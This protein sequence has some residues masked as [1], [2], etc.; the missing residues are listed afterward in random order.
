M[1]RIGLL[2]SAI[3]AAV[4]TMISC[5]EEIPSAD[6]TRKEWPQCVKDLVQGHKDGMIYSSGDIAGNT[7]VVTF[8][9]GT[10]ISIDRDEVRV[11]DCRYR[12]IPE[13]STKD[14]VWVVN[15][16]DSG[17][18]VEECTLEESQVV[19]IYFTDSSLWVVFSNGDKLEFKD[20]ESY[21]IS[22]FVFEAANNPQFEND[23]VCEINGAN[24][25]VV[26]PRTPES[27]VLVPTITSM[28]KEIRCGSETQENSV[29]S[30]DF[31]NP[32]KYTLILQDN[33]EFTY[34]VTVKSPIDFPTV[35]LVTENGKPITSKEDY[36]RGTVRF[37]DPGKVYSEVT[38]LELPT[39]LRGRGNTTW[40]LSDKKPYRIKLDEK[41]PVFGQAPN[42]D[43]TL[44]ANYSDKSLLRNIACMQ[45][46][47][48]AGFPWIPVTYSVDVYLNGEYRGV[49]TFS[50]QVEVGKSRIDIEVVEEGDV[51]GD[52]VT[53]GYLFELESLMDEPVCFRTA[54]KAP[55][56]FKDPEEPNAAQIEYVK[57]YF[58]AFEK[59]LI[60]G[61]VDVVESLIDIDSFIDF[62][63]V[64][65]LVK[66]ID[67]NI[68]KST[69]MTK[70]KGGKLRMHTLWDF[71]LALGN[72]DYFHLNP[73]CDSSPQ[74]WYVKFYSDAGA[75]T[76]WFHYMFKSEEFVEKVCRRWDEL[77][78]KFCELPKF[79]DEQAAFISK[80]Q[81]RNFTKWPILG[82]YVWPN[83]KVLGNWNAEVDYVK[84]FYKER[85]DWMNK[86]LK[87]L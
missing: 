83:M 18:A 24:I 64:Q 45:L 71:D 4:L 29:S 54:M 47:R 26:L 63:I 16:V 80:A 81:E 74:G 38:A 5:Q 43:W 15:G 60:E 35:Y 65:E 87:T 1:K 36:V 39:R 14:S 67:G 3:F 57:E 13:I 84:S 82:I 31:Y 30:Q 28:A 8:E 78:P 55:V 77:Y 66:N 51:D 17:I 56:M 7:L 2:L 6:Q 25:N 86:E 48:I 33:S 49:Y 59:A 72:C 23:I 11:I 73:G 9:G 61:K 50:E 19:C 62:F 53:G 79:I 32:V 69:Y 34:T 20:K 58:D 75:N 76:G 37:E 10:S 12:D 44:L 27:Y 41:S 40:T 42:K 22:S 85:L 46:G 52:A 68:R 21:L 70:S